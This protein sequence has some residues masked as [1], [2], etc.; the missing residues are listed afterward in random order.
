MFSTGEQRPTQRENKA[1][2]VVGLINWYSRA[3]RHKVE[4][5]QLNQI[6]QFD[7][8]MRY[9]PVYIYIHLPDS[10][11]RCKGVFHSSKEITSHFQWTVALIRHLNYELVCSIRLKSTSKNDQRWFGSDRDTCISPCWSISLHDQRRR[12]RRRRK[13]RM[14]DDGAW[15]GCV[16]G[17][18]DVHDRLRGSRWASSIES[19]TPAK[20]GK[21]DTP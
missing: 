12:R 3:E 9:L 19:R 6:I 7:L 8:V 18:F 13:D 10:N 15:E 21:V 20:V 16:P 2:C 4:M 17:W 5:T 11:R 14:I 1:T